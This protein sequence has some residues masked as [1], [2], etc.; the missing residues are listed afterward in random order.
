[1]NKVSCEGCGDVVP[2]YDVVH[3]GSI[4]N[5]YRKLCTRC[6]NA[7][8][9][10]RSGLDDFENVRFEPIGMIDCAGETHQFHFQTRLLGDMVTLDAFELHDGNRAGYE[11]QLIGDPDDDVLALLGRLIEKIRRALSIKHLSD[12]KR[13]GLQIAKETVRGRIDSNGSD[14][15]RDPVLVIDGREISWDEFGRMLMSFEGWQFKLQIF[16]RNDEP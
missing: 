8:V 6:F 5:G 7:E 9:A 1:M 3:Y 15:D 4:E 12:D 13:H 11:F 2:N 14:I 16:D 10:K